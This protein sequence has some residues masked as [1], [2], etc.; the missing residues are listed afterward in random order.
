MTRPDLAFS[1][2]QLGTFLQ[3]P[4]ETNPVA[5]YRVL[6]KAITSMIRGLANATFCQAGWTVASRRTSTLKNPLL[7]TYCLIDTGFI[8]S[9][10]E[11]K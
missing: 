3:H 8:H 6:V 2:S 5:V 1:F 11:L 9:T 7:A 10:L 4:G